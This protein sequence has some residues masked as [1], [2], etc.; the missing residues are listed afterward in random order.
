MSIG[1]LMR[2]LIKVL[3]ALADETRLRILKILHEKDELCVCEIMQVLDISQTRASRNLN[4]LKDVGFVKDRRDGLWVYYSINHEKINEF[5]LKLNE[6]IKQWLNDEKIIE[7]DRKKL[8][9]D[10][11]CNIKK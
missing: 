8:K 3:K 7:V 11:K 9:S 1:G 2:I 5:H 10:V 4:I 6:L